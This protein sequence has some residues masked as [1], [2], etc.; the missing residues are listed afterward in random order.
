AHSPVVATTLAARSGHKIGV[1]TLNVPA[2][3][4]AVDLTMVKLIDKQLARWEKNDKVVA[5]LMRGAGDKA[6]CAGGDIRQLYQSMTAEGAEQYRSA[7]D[8]FRC[9]YGKNFHVHLL[10]KPLIACG[11]GFVMGAG[12]GL[13][14]G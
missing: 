3:M 11:Y 5:V 6:F 4:N 9:E 7:D 13:F 12:L 2:A 1:L 8:Y 14:I 10:N